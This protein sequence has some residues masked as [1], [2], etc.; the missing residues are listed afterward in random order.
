MHNIGLLTKQDQAY[1]AKL[2]RKCISN[3]NIRHLENIELYISWTFIHRDYFLKMQKKKRD[4][5]YKEKLVKEVLRDKLIVKSIETK[6]ESL[7][8]QGP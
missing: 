5:D 7:R 2:N 1:I 6:K 4:K 8:G 3:V